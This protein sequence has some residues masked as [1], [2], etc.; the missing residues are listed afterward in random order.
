MVHPSTGQLTPRKRSRR[1]VTLLAPLVPLPGDSKNALPRESRQ[2]KVSSRLVSTQNPP[3]T[4]VA[5]PTRSRRPDPKP[6]PGAPT[7][8]VRVAASKRRVREPRGGASCSRTTKPHPRPVLP[9]PATSL[10]QAPAPSF[11]LASSAA[12][13]SPPAAAR[14]FP[15][16]PGSDSAAGAGARVSGAGR[17]GMSSSR[18]PAGSRVPTTPLTDGGW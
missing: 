13:A 3:Q 5:Q 8:P 11:P 2:T 4:V 15:A 9:P 18:R 12:F 7:S 14:S 6:K 16:A 10:H 1:R 17:R